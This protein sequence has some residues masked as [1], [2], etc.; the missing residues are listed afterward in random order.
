MLCQICNKNYRMQEENYCP[1]CYVAKLK[2]QIRRRNIQIKD[3][4]ARIEEF[5]NDYIRD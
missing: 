5:K 3:L 1:I 4:K 2:D